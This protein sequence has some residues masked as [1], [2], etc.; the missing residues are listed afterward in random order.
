MAWTILFFVC[1]FFSVASLYRWRW[2]NCIWIKY[3]ELV[4]ILLNLLHH[5]TWKFVHMINL[6]LVEV[7]LH[8]HEPKVFVIGESFICHTICGSVF[9]FYKYR[10]EQY[11]GIFARTDIASSRLNYLKNGSWYLETLTVCECRKKSN[12]FFTTKP[13]GPAILR[14]NYDTIYITMN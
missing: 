13:P 10:D 2:I 11:F 1:F 4:G 3:V 7:L 5:V 14:G 8:L 12:W 9:D 6:S